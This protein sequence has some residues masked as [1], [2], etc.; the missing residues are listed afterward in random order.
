MAEESEESTERDVDKAGQSEGSTA[1]Q[2]LSNR[3]RKAKN[4]CEEVTGG[5]YDAKTGACKK[6]GG[7]AP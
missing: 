3:K 7:A 1:N 2:L 4:M 5:V 6:R